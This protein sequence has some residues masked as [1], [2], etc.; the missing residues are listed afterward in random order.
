MEQTATSNDL[1]RALGGHWADQVDHCRLADLALLRG[2]PGAAA[3][4]LRVA[5]WSAEERRDRPGFVRIATSRLT[6]ARAT[7]STELAEQVMRSS[8]VPALD[9]GGDEVWGLFLL[10]RARWHRSQADRAA[11]W[12]CLDEATRALGLAPVMYHRMG[13][14]LLRAELLC[15][16]SQPARALPIIE[17]V[18]ESAA[19]AGYRPL[20]LLATAVRGLALARPG[21][22]GSVALAPP[23]LTRSNVPLALTTLEYGAAVLDVQ[24]HAERAEA[25]RRQGAELARRSG[26]AGWPAFTP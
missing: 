1:L 9:E 12:R 23:E 5:F 6:L 13:V 11:A 26:F 4:H 18:R 22:E 8:T 21:Q 10:E 16:A 15:D 2:S 25:L 7:G 3:E 14:D 17:G 19:S 24:G 20:H